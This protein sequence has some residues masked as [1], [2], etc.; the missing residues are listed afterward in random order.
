[1]LR[2]TIFLME[3]CFFCP[4]SPHVWW[5]QNA[6]TISHSIKWGMHISMQAPGETAEPACS[7]ATQT[8]HTA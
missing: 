6:N 4:K 1:M 7:S 5:T 2:V 8:L 3:T